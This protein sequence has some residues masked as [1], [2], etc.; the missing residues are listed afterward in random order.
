MEHNKK[1]IQLH[2]VLKV[3][4]RDDLIQTFILLMTSP[5]SHSNLMAEL[6]ARPGF[7]SHAWIFYGPSQC[8]HLLLCWGCVGVFGA[9]RWDCS[10]SP[11]EGSV[12]LGTVIWSALL[13]EHL[14]FLGGEFILL[15]GEL[16]F[17]LYQFCEV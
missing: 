2:S 5:R 14:I 17:W 13:P 8:P 4:F 10:L 1:V 9:G 12:F 15:N 7:L 11:V 6:W 3:P 16:C